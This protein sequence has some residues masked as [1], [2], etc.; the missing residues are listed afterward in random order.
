MKECDALESNS[1]TA[2]VPLMKKH[3]N[4]HAWSF[5]VFL[6]NNMVNLPVNIVLLD[7]NRNRI[8]YMGRG[9]CSYS[10]LISTGARI[11]AS[12]SEMTSPQAK[13]LHSTCNTSEAAWVLYTL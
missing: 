1:T 7:S 3:T 13:H 12:V 8:G 4:D 9:R 2:E 5:L 10:S 6:H 11:G